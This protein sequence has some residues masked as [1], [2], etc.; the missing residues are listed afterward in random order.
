LGQPRNQRLIDLGA[1]SADRR[2]NV[3]KSLRTNTHGVRNKNADPSQKLPTATAA[4]SPHVRQGFTLIELLVTIT[5]IAILAALLL[6]AIQRSREASRRVSCINNLRQ[7]SLACMNYLSAHRC[8][9]PGYLTNTDG[10][11]ILTLEPP[12]KI[13][14]FP[15]L[16]AANQTVHTEWYISD[17]WSWHALILPH[18]GNK[19]VAVQTGE[20]KGTPNNLAAL[21]VRVPSF[22]CP[23]LANGTVAYATF[24]NGSRS[25]FEVTNYRGVAGTNLDYSTSPS[26]IVRDGMFF[27]DSVIRMRDIID[28]ES[29][30][31]M[32]IESSFGLW[33]DAASAATRFADDDKNGIPDWGPDGAIPSA[34]PS[35]FDGHVYQPQV[36]LA[37]GPGSWHSDVVIV[38]IADGSCRSISKTTSFEI[39]QALS[40]RAGSERHQIPE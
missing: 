39:M 6:P 4:D 21:S 20:S 12:L 40:T 13:P 7:L 22:V 37:L 18:L 23:S 5:I 36:A 8:F 38:A 3:R 2:R 9:P 28:G 25:K 10:S 15:P 27:R 19:V 33:G 17:N 26:G 30:T 32:L 35:T 11:S 14:S 31:L 16:D 1:E 24:G 34:K 29:N